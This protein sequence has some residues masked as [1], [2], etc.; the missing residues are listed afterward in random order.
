MHCL[1]HSVNLC[2]QESAKQSR[3][4]SDAVNELYNFIQLSPKQLALFNT[5]KGELAPGNSTVKPLCSTRWTVHTPAINAVIKNYNVLLQEIETIQD[6]FSGEA[7]TTAA[8]LFSLM[9]KFR[10]Y[11]GLKLAYLIFVSVEQLATTLQAK[12]VTAQICLESGLAAKTFYQGIKP[13][14]ILTCCSKLL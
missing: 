9:K 6:V 7:S 1:A 8:G 3:P 12:N 14:T 4:I 5:L 13:M 2:L 11:F 10:T